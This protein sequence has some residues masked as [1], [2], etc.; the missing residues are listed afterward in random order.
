[1]AVWQDLLKFVHI[2]GVVFMSVPL[3][4]LVLVNERALLGPGM[5][6]AVDRYL[7]NLIRK[8]ALRCYVFQT[9]VLVSGLILTHLELG[10]SSLFTEWVLAAKTLLLLTLMGM[11]SYIHFSVQ[12]RIEQ[13][14]GQVQGDP[15]PQ[16]IAAALRP[17]RVRRKRLAGVCLF[18]VVT[19]VILGLQVFE[20]FNAWLTAGLIV[21][22]ALFAWRVYKTPIRFGWI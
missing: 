16:E 10:L 7:E 5:V 20:A 19:T 17:L 4:N 22:A 18:L 1:M 3:Y 6:Y 14:L 2:L 13:L 8:S 21:L 9:S 15:V 12:P 11:L